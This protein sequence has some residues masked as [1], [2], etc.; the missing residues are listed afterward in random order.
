MEEIV[1]FASQLSDPDVAMRLSER[2]LRVRAKSGRLVPLAANDAQRR[3]EIGRGQENIVL[4][5]RQ[6]GLSTWIAGRFLLK[7]MLVP[8]TSTL[9]VAHTR[10]SAEA[11]FATVARMW[12]NLPTEAQRSIG[13]RGRANSS[14]MT[15][16]LADS[17]FRVASAGELNA[18]RGL[19]VHNLHCSEV[20][21]WPGDAAETLAGLR[22]ALAPEGELV[23][24]STPNG[25]YGC[26]YAQWMRAEEDGM[27]RH[28][29]PWWLEPAYVGTTVTDM[30]AEETVLAEREGLSA[31]QLGFRRELTRRFGAMRSQEFVED[32]VSCFRVSGACFFEASTLGP[33]EACLWERLGGALRVWLPAVPGRRYIVAV[34]AAGGGSEGDFAAVQVIDEATGMQCAELQQRLGPRELARLA[35][36]IT[37]EYNGALLVVERNNHGAAVLAYLENE[38]AICLYTGR[39]R[40]AGWLTDAGSRPRMLSG[41]AVLLAQRPELVQSPRLLQ[42]CRSFV[43]D[44]GG[45]AAAAVGAHDDLVMSMAMAHAV[46]AESR[47]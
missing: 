14:Q 42:E 44:A 23:L 40:M 25:A 30:T 10:E 7:T 33:G 32:A 35:A 16:Q 36:E 19:T 38:A 13:L 43:T 39:D 29:F 41:L 27:V 24:E 2:W 3:F 4:K 1:G 6:M 15:F 9:M 20:A 17:S 46:R 45:R 37:R 47:R 26:F 34:D 11:L 12:E 31:E 22:A 5:A 21:R 18:G 8:G 28:F